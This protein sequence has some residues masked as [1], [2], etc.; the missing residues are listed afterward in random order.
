[1]KDK[2]KHDQVSETKWITAQFHYQVF[3][4]SHKGWTGNW[5]YSSAGI[6]FV[7]DPNHNTFYYRQGLQSKIGL[8]VRSDRD[9]TID[10]VSDKVI[11]IWLVSIDPP[12]NPNSTTRLISQF[13]LNE[14]VL[15]DWV[16]DNSLLR[17]MESCISLKRMRCVQ[18]TNTYPTSRTRE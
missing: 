10:L 2:L 5:W 17:V 4:N 3:I 18:K 1:M 11:T 7:L 12:R 16:L 13:S 15:M 8:M 6:L 9:L 14:S